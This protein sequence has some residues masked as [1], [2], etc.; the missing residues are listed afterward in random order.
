MVIIHTL[1]TSQVKV[2]HN[3]M[4]IFLYVKVS[5][6]VYCAMEVNVKKRRARQREEMSWPPL[7]FSSQGPEVKEDASQV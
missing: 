7:P 5:C 4:S 1:P 2:L 3:I 6:K